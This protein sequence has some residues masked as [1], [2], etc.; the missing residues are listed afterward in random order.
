MFCSETHTHMA[1]HLDTEVKPEPPASDKLKLCIVS[2]DGSEVYFCVKPH[3]RL[4]KLMD[5]YCERQGINVNAIR[6]LFDGSRIRENDTPE[7]L[8]MVDG[9]MLDAMVQQ[10]GGGLGDEPTLVMYAPLAVKLGLIP[11]EEAILVHGRNLFYLESDVNLR[12][13]FP[14]YHWK[15]VQGIIVNA[16]TLSDWLLDYHYLE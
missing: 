5:V 4:G 16:C 8:G 11:E 1:E 3:T 15:V 10:V 6:I 12:V 14:Q 13:R 9:D 2:S 7:S